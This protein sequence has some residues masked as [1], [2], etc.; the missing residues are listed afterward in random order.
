MATR[1]EYI[2]ALRKADAA[3]DTKAA[4]AIVRKIQALGS[5]VQ[6]AQPAQPVEAPSSEGVSFNP[7]NVWKALKDSIRPGQIGKDIQKIMGTDLGA[8]MDPAS[9]LNKPAPEPQLPPELEGVPEFHGGGT[10]TGQ[11]KSFLGALMTPDIE[12]RAKLLEGWG[13]KTEKIGDVFVVVNPKTGRKQPIDKP[14]WSLQDG[15]SLLAET[16]K[17]ATAGKYAAGG[18]TI[19]KRIGRGLVGGAAT[20]TANEVALQSRG[21]EFDTPDVVATTLI[22]VGVQALIPFLGALHRQ[23][24]PVTKAKYNMA[25][26]LEEIMDVTDW[27]Y[28]DVMTAVSQNLGKNTTPFEAGV[29]LAK[30]QLM[31][32]ALNDPKKA[33][34]LLEKYTSQLQGTQ[35]DLARTFAALTNKSSVEA[36]ADTSI[37]SKKIINNKQNLRSAYDGV[38][39]DKAL[40]GL[41]DIPTQEYVDELNEVIRD[42]STRKSTL[43][44]GLKNKVENLT[45]DEYLASLRAWKAELSGAVDGGIVDQY[46]NVAKSTA[47]QGPKP[48][49]TL[50]AAQFHSIIK[51]IRHQATL[52]NKTGSSPELVTALLKIEKKMVKKLEAL[53]EFEMVM[54]K[55]GKL[56]PLEVRDAAGKLIKVKREYSFAEANKRWRAST[57]KINKLLKSRIGESAELEDVEFDTFLKSIF[58]TSEG[59]NKEL[60]DDFMRSLRKQ[61]PQSADDLY[62]AYFGTKIKDAGKTPTATHLFESL[63]PKGH[64]I[65][66]TAIYR[67]APTELA[68]KNIRSFEGILRRGSAVEKMDLV[69]KSRL[70]W[71]TSKMDP[72]S[73]HLIYVRQAFSRAVGSGQRARL[74][75]AWF[76]AATNPK[77]AEEWNHLMNGRNTLKM[78]W[79]QGAHKKANA[80]RAFID[81]ADVF[82]SKVAAS[83]SEGEW[84]QSMVPGAAVSAKAEV[85]GQN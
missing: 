38:Y 36:L 10:Y 67:F 19:I 61:D 16:G 65:E 72:A 14:G 85:M 81:E 78:A 12:K 83:I 24:S 43:R 42:V 84:I 40:K 11:F 3:G 56:V 52:F 46:G 71:G 18:K 5:T 39:Y 1:E 2:G 62:G 41:D 27:S 13:F 33:D 54:G 51:S 68:R 70:Q 21:L 48:T 28:D 8:K 26:T 79:P 15:L 66:S 44:S 76:K 20:A 73:S 63:F 35:A 31:L 4:E 77:W 32:S 64:P 30:E 75:E 37:V 55:D 7:G 29:P 47:K 23:L 6:P 57:E 50:K 60:A 25:K 34:Y 45:S 17:Y 53:T 49:R 80:V 58:E 69:D 22:E 59:V 82:A 74:G 9:D